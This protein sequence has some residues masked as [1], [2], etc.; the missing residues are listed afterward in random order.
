MRIVVFTVGT[1]GDARP[2]AALGRGLA[3]RGHRVT[4][5]TAAHHAP[6][7]SGAGL[8]HAEIPSDFL[9][10]MVREQAAMD[11]GSQLRL[12]RRVMRALADWAPEWARRGRALAADADLVIGSGSGTTLAASVAELHGLPSVQAQFM[13]LTPSRAFP[14]VW[15]PPRGAATG[16]LRGMTNLASARAVRMLVWRLQAD[17]VDALR[18]ELGLAPYPWRGPWSLPGRR[19]LYAYS[20]HLLPQPADWPCETIRVT[21]SWFLDQGADWTPPPDLAAFLAAGPKPIYVGFGSML[22]GQA[23]ALSR[24]VLEAVRRSGE[25]AVIAGGWGA[26][27]AGSLNETSGDVLFIDGAPHD[28]LFPRVRLAVHHGGS[29]TTAAAARAG[30]PQVIV[31]FTADQ[32]FW[33]WC[34]H[35]IG[36]NP[37]RLE[38]KTLDADRLA[39]AIR[40]ALDGSART[41]AARLGPL[42]EAEDGVGNAIDTL[43]R[44]GLLD[45]AASSSSARA[46][47]TAAL[48]AA[49]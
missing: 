6:L 38:R 11:S 18:G 19:T 5:A 9:E 26:L 41:L 40:S 33:S 8:V 1:Q 48:E 31:P 44:W 12:G 29:G 35:A 21:G 14:P 2:F 10:L 3:A 39:Q 27:D 32:P 37:V 17:A 42:I 24:I 36:L 7:V 13:P 43:E 20:R 49:C 46:A 16:T 45:R 22:T 47:A 23:A 34:L 4:I 30:V 15:P 25:R 28:W